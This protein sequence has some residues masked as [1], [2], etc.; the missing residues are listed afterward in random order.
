MKIIETD[1]RVETGPLQFG[2]DWPG[3]FVRG[4]DCIDLA[5][6]LERALPHLIGQSHIIASRFVSTIFYQVL[7]AE[8]HERI[9]T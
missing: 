3:L 6:A 8:K 4:D 2:D 5:Y 7:G 9:N 1:Q